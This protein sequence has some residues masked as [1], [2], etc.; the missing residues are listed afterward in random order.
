MDWMRFIK[1]FLFNLQQNFHLY[2]IWCG[3]LDVNKMGTWQSDSRGGFPI[4]GS[5]QLLFKQKYP[6]F[7]LTVVPL[8]ATVAEL[9]QNIGA[10]LLWP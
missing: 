4:C 9:I 10:A 5:S 2:F 3:E 7:T 1:N 6:A 8:D